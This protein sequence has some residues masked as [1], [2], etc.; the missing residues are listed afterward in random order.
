MRKKFWDSR[1]VAEKIKTYSGLGSVK[2]AWGP[3]TGNAAG[4][5]I[6]AQGFQERHPHFQQAPTSGTAGTRW[7]SK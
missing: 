2:T 1:F 5:E 6:S 4:K 3:V 7:Q